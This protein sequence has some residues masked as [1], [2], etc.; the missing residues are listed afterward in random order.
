MC[1][2]IAVAGAHTLYVQCDK[3]KY[4]YEKNSKLCTDG[5]KTTTKGMWMW[6]ITLSREILLKW[7]EWETKRVEK[8][9]EK[10]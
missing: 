2:M 3:L 8:S 5:S 9:S 7:I 6:V 4:F 10:I 1:T